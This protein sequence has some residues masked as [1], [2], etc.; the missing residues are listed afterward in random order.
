MKYKTVLC[1]MKIHWWQKTVM[2]KSSLTE[3]ETIRKKPNPTSTNFP[4]LTPHILSKY[5]DITVCDFVIKFN[6]VRFFML[7]FKRN[8]FHTSYYCKNGKVDTFMRCIRNIQRL[9]ARHGFRVFQLDTD[10]EF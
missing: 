2:E 8:F 7:I 9:A 6:E 5:R 3:G 10:G 1:G 4:P